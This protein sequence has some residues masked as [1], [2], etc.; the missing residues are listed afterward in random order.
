M[1]KEMAGFGLNFV[2]RCGVLY[3]FMEWKVVEVRWKDSDLLL[4]FGFFPGLKSVDLSN[5]RLMTFF[6]EIIVGFEH[7]ECFFVQ[8]WDQVSSVWFIFV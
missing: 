1:P 8:G 6:V 2:Y 4:Y 5:G 7:A 3:H